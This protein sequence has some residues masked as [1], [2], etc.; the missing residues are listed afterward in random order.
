M[1]TQFWWFFDVAAIALLLVTI[2]LSGKKG[3]SK[4]VVTAI[5]CI[6][7]VVIAF[8]TCGGVA[9][10]VYKSSVKQSNVK[11]I[12]K[13]LEKNSV[14][15]KLKTYLEGLGYSIRIDEAILSD[16]L[17]GDEDVYDALYK[18]VNNINGRTV[19]TK[20]IFDE[21]L[22][23]GFAKSVSDILAQELTTYEA[24]AAGDKIRSAE[25]QALLKTDIKIIC[26]PNTTTAASRIESSYVAQASKD[27]IR[28]LS[29]VI[30]VFVIMIIVKIID[31]LIN[32]EE[33]PD[34][35]SNEI[36][37]HVLGGVM[38][39][40]EGVMLLFVA[41]AAVRACVIF[42][43]DDMM[44]FNSETIDKTLAF[45]HIYNLVMKL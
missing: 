1:S 23:E 42:G 18:Y 38:G 44:L 33:K 3:F 39:L 32:G 17:T 7:S 15:T 21:K 41:A 14:Q 27:I 31:K 6:L 16:I 10:F 40:A 30:L 36:T 12:D 34:R 4:A 9:D 22:T 2:F 29:F 20:E 35:I 37:S 24:K 26:D 43:G 13:A 11:A 19:D 5:G 8:P 28:I 45:K 25:G